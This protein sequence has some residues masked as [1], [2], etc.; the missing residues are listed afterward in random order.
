MFARR[1]LLVFFV[2]FLLIPACTRTEDKQSASTRAEQ[3]ATFKQLPE[4]QEIELQKPVKIKLK[5]NTDGEY[6]WELS[7]DDVDEIIKIDKR[8]RELLGN[9]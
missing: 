3:E 1:L 7:G 5:R 8:L 2:I 4:L 9:K 6:S